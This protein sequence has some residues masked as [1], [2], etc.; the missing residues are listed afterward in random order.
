MFIK[1]LIQDASKMIIG[2]EINSEDLHLF[3]IL[4]DCMKLGVPCK[5]SY[6]NPEMEVILK[7]LAGKSLLRYD[8]DN[9]V[10]TSKFYAYIINIL[11]MN[12]Y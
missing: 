11:E 3:K 2:R 4:R 5:N 6:F 9:I 10:M 8:L 12:E 1:S 7:E